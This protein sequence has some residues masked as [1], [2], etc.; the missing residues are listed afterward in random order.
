MPYRRKGSPFYQY[1]FTVSGIRFRGSC[2]TDD[3]ETAKA[4][5]AKLRTEALQQSKLG[6][7]REITLNAASARYWE[8]VLQ[9]QAW[10]EVSAKY[11]V[12]ELLKRPSGETAGSNPAMACTSKINQQKGTTMTTLEAEIAYRKQHLESVKGKGY[13]VYN[14]KNRP[15]EE[16]PIIYGFNNGGEPGWYSAC[17]LAEDG[18][19]LGGHVCSHE[20]YMCSDLGILEG[21]RPDRHEGF[22]KHYPDGYR[23]DFVPGP[24]VKTHA[25]LDAAYKRNQE[26]AAKAN[27][28]EEAA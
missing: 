20:A 27:A 25:G 10:G 22:R 9:H 12:R 28:K 26:K 1:D 18:E 3:K 8:E 16:L 17:L 5:E 11:T 24:E 15:L 4:I 6:T 21:S 2:E 13:A 19:G 14:P 7:R 23:M